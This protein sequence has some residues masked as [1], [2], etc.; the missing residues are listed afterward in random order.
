M[1]YLEAGGANV[2]VLHTGHKR[3]LQIPM[4]RAIETRKHG[5]DLLFCRIAQV[6]F[7][8]DASRSNK[9]RVKVLNMI[10][11]KENDALLR[12]CNTVQCVQ[13]PTERDHGLITRRYHSHQTIG[14]S[15]PS[16]FFLPLSVGLGSLGE[17]GIDVFEEHDAS[18]WHIT[19]EV[20]QSVIGQAAL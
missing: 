2:L 15:S 5:S 3:I 14:S 12:R 4:V 17:G 10:C 18:F 16:F 11:G 19:Q 20:I 9:C 1:T 8:I 6:L 7:H 13:Q